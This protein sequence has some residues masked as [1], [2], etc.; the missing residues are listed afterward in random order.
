MS[1]RTLA[2]IPCLLLVTACASS[3]ERWYELHFEDISFPSLHGTVITVLE[4]EGFPVRMRDPTNGNIESE[5]VYGQASGS[6]R[7]ASRRS[8]MVEILPENGIL[9]V[10]IRV[11]EE[12]IR[13]GGML[14]ARI[15]DSDEWEE[16]DDNMD[17]AEFLATKLRILLY[18]KSIDIAGVGAAVDEDDAEDGEVEAD[19][20]GSAP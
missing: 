17:D 9:S 16:A 6:V 10:R 3:G 4:T 14:A 8:A 19:G 2:L 5:W 15:R 11:R 7:A 12:I 13:T 1:L 18:D 20:D